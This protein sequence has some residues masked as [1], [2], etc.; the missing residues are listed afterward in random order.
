MNTEYL[1]RYIASHLHTYVRSFKKDGQ[2]VMQ[3]C[4][5]PDFKDELLDKGAALQYLL[6][7]SSPDMPVL[8]SGSQHIIYASV[9][10]ADHIYI[11]GPVCTDVP[12]SLSHYIPDIAFD[13]SWLFTVSICPMESL[14]QNVLLL[15]NLH[16]DKILDKDIFLLHNCIDK[17][18]EDYVQKDYSN[19]VFRNQET[20]HKHNPYD[21]E[22]REQNSI[23][24]GDIEQLKKSIAEDFT[25]EYGVL[26]KDKLRSVKNLCIVVIALA[27]RTAIEGGVLPEVSFS[28][29]DS[30][31]N[32]IEELSNIE[33]IF[34]LARQAEFQYTEMVHDILEQKNINACKKE[35]NPHIIKCKDY[36]F[37]HL[38]DKIYIRDIAGE[39][40]I[41]PNYLAELFKDCEG[42]SI[43]EFVNKEKAGLAKNLL[44]YSEYSYIE[45]ATYLGYSSQSHFGK[46]FK[47]ITGYTPGQYRSKY[48]VKEFT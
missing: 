36:I 23:R 21:Q 22:L 13:E 42:I 11:V 32:K 6:K 9:A 35:N 18:E 10:A 19:I 27:S 20:G 47:E 5:R 26:A 40:G 34:H 37:R 15:H 29:S 39:I 38:H 8:A 43:L 41:H 48:G 4:E 25:G 2:P 45:I 44:M 28:L 14:V 16:Q 46:Q 12:A 3:I 7:A 24:S 17:K 1:M 31:I 33:T 30:Y